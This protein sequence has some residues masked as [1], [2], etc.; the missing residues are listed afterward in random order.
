V[1][2]ATHAPRPGLQ[3]CV[4]ACP[5]CRLAASTADEP[6]CYNP[7]H[8]WT[9]ICIVVM[10][11]SQQVCSLPEE[12]GREGGGLSF[13]PKTLTHTSMYRTQQATEDSASSFQ[14]PYTDRTLEDTCTTYRRPTFAGGQRP[15]R[16][17][18]AAAAK[19]PLNVRVVARARCGIAVVLCC[20]RGFKA[21]R[22]RQHVQLLTANACV[23]QHQKEFTPTRLHTT[24]T[25]GGHT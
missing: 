17:P 15:S 8:P 6:G 23:Q 22:P 14:Q 7:S 12:N 20:G 4:R 13:A 3:Y 25:S 19:P 16:P 18:P 24:A 5:C 11:P 9:H 21:R 2:A 1:R 10:L